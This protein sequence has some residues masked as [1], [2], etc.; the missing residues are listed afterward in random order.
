MRSLGIC[1]G[2]H[3][4]PQAMR[5]LLLQVLSLSFGSLCDPDDGDEGGLE[6]FYFNS[7]SFFVCEKSPAFNRAK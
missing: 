3:P 2:R 6:I 1:D 7:I 4:L 5:I